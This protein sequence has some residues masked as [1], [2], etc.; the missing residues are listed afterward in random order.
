M[1][2]HAALRLR[3]QNEFEVQTL[4]DQTPMWGVG[5]VGPRQRITPQKYRAENFAVRSELEYWP[6][7]AIAIT[8]AFCPNANCPEHGFAFVGFPSEYFIGGKLICPKCRTPVKSRNPVKIGSSYP[9]ANHVELVIDPSIPPEALA[10]IT[11]LSERV[12]AGAIS[13]NDAK[14]EAAKIA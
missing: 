12:K 10:A 13:P 1:A 8:L 3:L 2:T 9:N 14:R 6:C 4:L 11:G 5:G 7:M